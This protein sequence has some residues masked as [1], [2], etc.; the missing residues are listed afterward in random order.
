MRDRNIL[1]ELFNIALGYLHLEMGLEEHILMQDYVMIPLIHRGSV[2]AYANN[3]V[4]VR[5]NT[6]DSEL[7]NIADWS[8]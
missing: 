8:R 5:M 1:G 7:W 2:S 6:W 4:G 3:L